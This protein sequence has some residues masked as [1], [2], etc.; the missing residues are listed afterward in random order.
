MESTLIFIMGIG[1]LVIACL[2]VFLAIFLSVRTDKL[3]K[4]E[5]RLAKEMI[6]QGKKETQQIIGESQKMI[7]ETQKMIEEGKKETHQMIAESQR[8]IE[9]GRRETRDLLER[10]DE[11]TAKI[12]EMIEKISSRRPIFTAEEQSEYKKKEV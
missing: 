8:M 3:V 11:R 12:A 9:D 6:E 2:S 7:M 10:M 1:S 5:D 4:L